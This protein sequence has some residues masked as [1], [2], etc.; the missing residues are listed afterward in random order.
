MLSVVR[1]MGVRLAALA[2]VPVRVRLEQGGSITLGYFG[3]G[4]VEY[5]SDFMQ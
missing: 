3:N 4:K 5:I 2:V 1:E